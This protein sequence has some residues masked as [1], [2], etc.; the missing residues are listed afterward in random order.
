VR[1]FG[2]GLLTQ[3]QAIGDQ[4][5]ADEGDEH[6]IELVEAREAASIAFEPVEQPLGP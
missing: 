6:D 3:T 1:R 5:K 4:R 2:Q